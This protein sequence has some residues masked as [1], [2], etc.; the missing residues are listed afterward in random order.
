MLTFEP[1]SYQMCCNSAVAVEALT[2]VSDS[3]F[4]AFACGNSIKAP[5][6]S[7]ISDPALFST[8]WSNPDASIGFAV[9]N[10][11]SPFSLELSDVAVGNSDGF[12]GVYDNQ[13]CIAQN[14]FRS[15]PDQSCCK[16]NQGC[17]SNV[18][19]DVASRG[20]IKD[21]L[22]QKHGVKAKSHA[23]KSKIALRA[24]NRQI[25]HS[26]IISGSPEVGKGK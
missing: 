18:E 10:Q 6:K 5:A 3:L 14:Q 11:Q 23:A 12:D 15:N 9:V 22:C 13:I 26:S 19:N 7:T 25:V 1:L 4:F 20:R 8:G 16:S 21:C 2:D 24:I 17:C